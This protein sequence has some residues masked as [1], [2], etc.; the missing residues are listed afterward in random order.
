[1]YNGLSAL[2]LKVFTPAANYI[3]FKGVQNLYEE[4]LAK[5]ILIR[6]CGNYAGLNKEFYRVAVKNHNENEI[7]LKEIKECVMSFQTHPNIH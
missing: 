6:Q 2:G 3:F 7:L 4:L 5:G 1:L